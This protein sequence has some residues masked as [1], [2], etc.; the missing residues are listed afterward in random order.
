MKN[1][2]YMNSFCVYLVIGG[3][4]LGVALWQQRG[5][6][7]AQASIG[8]LSERLLSLRSD[9]EANQAHLAASKAS[10]NRLEAACLEVPQRRAESQNRLELDGFTPER[11]GWWP[12]NRPYFYLRKDQLPLARLRDHNLTPEE[13]DEAGR[14]TLAEQHLHT[15]MV[16]TRF[17]EE[18]EDGLKLNPLIPGL[19]G[20]TRNEAAET[21][22]IFQDL[23]REVRLLEV[24][25]MARVEPA[26]KMEDGREIIARL[27][28]LG[29]EVRALREQ[30]RSKLKALL[31]DP[32]AAVLEAQSQSFF[33]Q[34]QDG[35]GEEYDRAF[36]S[37]TDRRNLWVRYSS[38]NGPDFY[39]YRSEYRWKMSPGELGH[40]HLFGPG[41]P[42][43]LK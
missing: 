24:A 17:F 31:G 26:E 22:A 11:E 25:R 2:V 42:C 35:L 23:L 4:S 34:Y 12:T 6:D 29:A 16:S 9:L 15:A 36:I 13:L 38:P 27:P 20:M 39:W 37:D 1:F 10:L 33:N 32:R 40:D 28:A 3:T 7:T 18:A 30:S 21:G 41:G 19:L 43:E 5:I 14:R 8:R